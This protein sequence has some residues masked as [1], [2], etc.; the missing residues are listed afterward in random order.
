MV[1]ARDGLGAGEE[2]RE[3]GGGVLEGGRVRHASQ[4]RVLLL[5][6]ACD[7]AHVG[8][9]VLNEVVGLG[10]GP[11]RPP[12]EPLRYA[13]DLV[14]LLSQLR[15]YRLLAS[16]PKLLQHSLGLQGGL[17]GLE[18]VGPV[19]DRLVDLPLEEA[20]EALERML[21]VSAE[22][23]SLEQAQLRLPEVVLQQLTQPEQEPVA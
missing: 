11:L 15:A 21:D 18:V 6:H 13:Q 10:L 19:V 14:H 4:L 20:L 17:R 5:E 1:D 23:G 7:R 16:V 22:L 9:Q 3:P 2:L 8:Y 12:L